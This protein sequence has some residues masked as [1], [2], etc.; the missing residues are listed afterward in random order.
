MA[1]VGNQGHNACPHGCGSFRHHHDPEEAMAKSSADW[2]YFQEKFPQ[3]GPPSQADFGPKLDELDASE[4]ALAQSAEAFCRDAEAYFA[5]MEKI[6]KMADGYKGVVRDLRKS[7][8]GISRDFDELYDRV[9]ARGCIALEIAD[10][11]SARIARN[12]VR[13]Y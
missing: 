6:R 9:F 5:K 4:A 11:V 13:S 1:V 8:T 12:R 10:D 3:F 2:Q 7:C